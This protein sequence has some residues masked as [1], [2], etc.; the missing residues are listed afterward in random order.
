MARTFVQCKFHIDRSKPEIMLL[1]FLKPG[2][3]KATLLMSTSI[4]RRSIEE[5]SF[6][7]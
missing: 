3:I 6:L 1:L 7:C 4:L 5:T 2:R